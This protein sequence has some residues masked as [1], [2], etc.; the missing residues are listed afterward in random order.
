MLF[1]R[2]RLLSLGHTL[3]S[4]PDLHGY[5]LMGVRFDD[6]AM[7]YSVTMMRAVALL[8][9]LQT[10][11]NNTMSSITVQKGHDP[12]AIDFDEA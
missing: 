1:W 5:R 10:A 7:P 2:R 12:G 11:K 4:T 8:R 9:W 3:F 6:G